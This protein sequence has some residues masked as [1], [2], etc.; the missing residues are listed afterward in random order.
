MVE[1][2]SNLLGT[3]MV[4]L[5][6]ELAFP[7]PPENPEKMEGFR[8]ECKTVVL[9]RVVDVL[10]RS[11]R[12][13]NG[14]KLFRDL[15]NRERRATTAIGEGIAIPHV[16]TMQPQGLIMCFLRFRQG[17]EFMS[18]DGAPV[19]FVFGLATPPYADREYF[20][21]LTWLGRIFHDCFWLREALME[22]R[23]PAEV[24]G[25]LHGLAKGMD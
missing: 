5:D 24:R 25:I 15:L 20:D 22:A 13:R 14:S 4:E 17:I 10:G 8:W 16:R 2:I 19:H 3:E 18:L 1:D 12:V 7:E 21:V 11:D 9:Q 6:P 23:D